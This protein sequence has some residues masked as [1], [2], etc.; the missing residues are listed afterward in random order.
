MTIDRDVADGVR[1]SF[2]V[3]FP[4]IERD[5]VQVLVDGSPVPFN[6]VSD[7]EIVLPAPPAT[8]LEVVRTRE[9][10]SVPLVDFTPGS[11]L[12]EEELDTIARQGLFSAQEAKVSISQ[13]VGYSATFDALTANGQRITNLAGPINQNDAVTVSWVQNFGGSILSQ[14]QAVVGQLFSLTAEVTTLAPNQEA[15]ADYSASTGVLS[16][17]IPKGDQ[18]DP[19]PA[20]P[21]GP[22]GVPGPAG[23]EGPQ[24]LPGPIGNKGPDGDPGPM[25]PTPLGLAFG[26]FSIN[27]DGNLQIEFYGDAN[28]NDFSIDPNGYLFVE[29]S[30]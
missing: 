10:P 20:G 3:T 17:Y 21:I 27:S 13:T 28:E 15:R 29:T 8:G 23:P 12:N 30:T 1:T 25:G 22:Q 18:G 7:A 4:F 24:G 14:A 16:L 26:T 19:G 9:T 6:W 5:H 2:P 11:Q